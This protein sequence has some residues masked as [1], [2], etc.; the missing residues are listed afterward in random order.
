[1]VTTGIRRC[2]VKF[3]PQFSLYP[4][5]TSDSEARFEVPHSGHR[6]ARRPADYCTAWYLADYP[7]LLDSCRRRAR[8]PECKAN[9]VEN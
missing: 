8:T 4:M 1:M 3:A 2:I 6:R 7:R 9:T 5:L